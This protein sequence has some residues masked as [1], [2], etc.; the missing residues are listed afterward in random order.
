[1]GILKGRT[2]FGSEVSLNTAAGT[3]A[4]QSF[5]AVV[6]Q[7]PS[8]IMFDNQSNVTVTISDDGTTDGKTFIAGEVMILD[9]RSNSLPPENEFT[10]D[11]G[12]Q[13]F[14]KSAAGSGSFRI[15]YVYA[16]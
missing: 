7:N 4:Y 10:W 5:S 11:I 9:L 8:I 3:G 13:F 1:M 12:T 2:K 6:S 16:R 15:S 14:G